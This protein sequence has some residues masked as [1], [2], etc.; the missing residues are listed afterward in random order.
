MHEKL[1]SSHFRRVAEC[2]IM[3]I[4]HPLPEVVNPS[5][6]ICDKFVNLA[7]AH[8]MRKNI[9]MDFIVFVVFYA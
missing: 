1:L 9:F 8:K 5:K 2:K 4:I 6:T 7:Q 3:D